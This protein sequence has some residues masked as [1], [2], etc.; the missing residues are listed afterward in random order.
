MRG[1]S[2][3]LLLH[4]ARRHLDMESS[5]MALILTSTRRQRCR[6]LVRNLRI[7]ALPH[8]EA[9][10]GAGLG[11]RVL[12]QRRRRQPRR[13]HHPHQ[14]HRPALLRQ[15]ARRAAAGHDV[16]RDWVLDVSHHSDP[17]W[18]ARLDDALRRRRAGGHRHGVDWHH[19]DQLGL[20]RRLA[21]ICY[22]GGCAWIGRRVR[23]FALFRHQEDRLDQTYICETGVLLDTIFHFSDGRCYHQ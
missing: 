22:V 23:C 9:G 1:T 20:V 17:V 14:D 3:R 2:V 4:A 11:L 13:R 5:P 8:H 16:H 19:Q 18:Y 21:G 6:Q 15:L 10:H 12:R 7:L